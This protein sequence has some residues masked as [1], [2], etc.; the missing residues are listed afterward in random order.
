MP[1][2]VWTAS[3]RLSSSA[4][5]QAYTI[6]WSALGQV[7]VGGADRHLVGAGEHHVGG[8]RA[9]GDVG[10]VLLGVDQVGEDRVAAGPHVDRGSGRVVADGEP[11]LSG[12]RSGRCR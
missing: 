12:R 6:V 3:L 11:G 10:A 8:D 7:E 4:L 2:I 1:L 9:G 5:P